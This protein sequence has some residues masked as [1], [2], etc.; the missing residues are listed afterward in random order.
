MNQIHLAD[1]TPGTGQ[2]LGVDWASIAEVAVVTLVAAVVIVTLYSV[3]LRLLAVGQPADGEAA[4]GGPS[5]RP[6]GATIGAYLCIG[7]GIVAVVYGIYLIVPI[8][9]LK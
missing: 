2:F 4:T 9:H 5:A 1:A 3:G 8:F 7:I 6:I